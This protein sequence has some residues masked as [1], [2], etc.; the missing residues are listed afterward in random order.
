[1]R[2]SPF[3]NRQPSAARD[4]ANQ[5]V[6]KALAEYGDNGE[7]SRHV[8]HFFF[9]TDGARIQRS[10]AAVELRSLGFEVDL[11]KSVSGLLAEE[12][13]EVASEDFDSLTQALS[14]LAEGWGWT[15]DGFECAV[16]KMN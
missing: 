4:E 7:A 8:I 13:R 9:E 3:P 15:Y 5:K 14:D 11:E 1:M 12:W 10:D 6:R 16:E 2:R